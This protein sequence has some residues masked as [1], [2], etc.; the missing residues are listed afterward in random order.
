MEDALDALEHAI[1]LSEAR[2]EIPADNVTKRVA[3]L[4]RRIQRTHSRCQRLSMG[5]SELRSTCDSEVSG[6]LQSISL[7]DDLTISTLRESELKAGVRPPLPGLQTAWRSTARVSRPSAGAE[8]ISSTH[9]QQRSV[10]PTPTPAADSHSDND[11]DGDLVAPTYARVLAPNRP[12]PMASECSRPVYPSAQGMAT[13]T[14][15]TAEIA[16]GLSRFPVALPAWA[17]TVRG[18]RLA[19]GFARSAGRRVRASSDRRRA[20]RALLLGDRGLLR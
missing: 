18:H 8:S 17:A 13:L 20:Q 6:V 11:S 2:H 9:G 16:R 3:E 12:G 4:Y 7:D 19:R 14:K 15:T 10:R 5:A 1:A